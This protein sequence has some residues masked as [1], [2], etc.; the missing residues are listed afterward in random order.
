M[1]T[2]K[3][4][5]DY[6]T[7]PGN[8][9][10]NYTNILFLYPIYYLHKLQ[11]GKTSTRKT[12]L[13]YVHLFILFIAS[14]YYHSNPTNNTFIPDMFAVST[15]VLL[16]SIILLDISTKNILY[17]YLISILSVGYFKQ[18]GNLLG[19]VLVLGGIPG[20]VAFCLWNTGINKELIQISVLMVMLRLVEYN[21]KRIYNYTKIINGHSLKHILSVC[22]IIKILQL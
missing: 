5:T 2:I 21:D 14:I 22:A 7:Y 1:L 18:S 15:L 16:S 13:L 17:I 20:Y 11:K 4:P 9:L 3:I 19:H 8:N 10:T 6:H 12:K